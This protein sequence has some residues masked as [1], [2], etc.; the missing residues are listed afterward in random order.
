MSTPNSQLPTPKSSRSRVRCGI[1]GEPADSLRLS[2]RWYEPAALGVGSWKLGVIVAA[3]L[4]SATAC[5]RKIR[6]KIKPS[7][8]GI[9]LSAHQRDDHHGGLQ[10]PDRPRPRAVRQAGAVRP[11]LVPVRRRCDDGGSVDGGED[12]RAGAAGGEVLGLDR[13]AGRIAG[14]SSSTRTMR[15]GTRG[16]PKG[17]TRCACRSRRAPARTWKR[18]AF[19]FPAVDGRKTEL[20]IH[21]GSV[22]VPMA[23]EV[24]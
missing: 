8:H 13:A 11:H 9:G 14:R 23:I 2:A 20:V 6:P 10:P 12:R 18:L 22:V 24:P 4:L 1:R 3:V 7:Q 19:Y 15:S 5:R 21:W 16:I 17:R